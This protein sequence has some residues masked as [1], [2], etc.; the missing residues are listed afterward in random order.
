[1]AVYPCDFDQ[2]RY[3][4]A[5]QSMYFTQVI[6]TSADSYAVRYCPLHFKEVWDSVRKHMAQLEDNSSWS[7]TCEECSEPRAAGLYAKVYAY[8]EPVQ[9]YC[10]DLCA[11][12]LGR[13]G[14]EW[15]IYNGRYLQSRSDGSSRV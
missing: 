5:Q 11:S 4:L 1:M 10:V 6:G 14:Q 7:E 9:Q 2:R 13:L 3:P 12:C 8:N 15:R